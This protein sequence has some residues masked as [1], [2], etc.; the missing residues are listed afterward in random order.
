MLV[1]YSRLLREIRSHTLLR[2]LCLFAAIESMHRQP[3][4]DMLDR[5]EARFPSERE[6]VARIRRLVVEH[7]DCFDRT[8]RPGHVTAS[9]WV[10]TRERDR[11][12]LVHHRK[13]DRW[14]QPGGHADGQSDIPAAALREAVEETGLGCLRLCDAASEITPLDLDVHIIPAR[15]D[16]SGAMVDDAHEHHDVRFLVVAEGDLAPRVSDESHDVRW[17]TA[18][19]LHAA[20]DEESVLR[21]W[22]K[23]RQSGSRQ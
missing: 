15:F 14:L 2:L 10:T 11:V 12:L 7:V 9:A 4:L 19:E 1:F 6:V 5:Y 17:F 22:R 16:A 8:C 21:L 13:L 20:T 3:L 18:A 23:S